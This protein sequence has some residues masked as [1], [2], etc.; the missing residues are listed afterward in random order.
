MKRK[1]TY[2]IIILVL[3]MTK[4]L[5][6]VEQADRKL[7]TYKQEV[8][9]KK[10]NLEELK[11]KIREKSIH[12]EKLKDKENSLSAE[13]RKINNNL[14]KTEARIKN[15]NKKIG[16]TERE[17]NLLQKKLVAKGL[18]ASDSRRQ[19]RKHLRLLYKYQK[20]NVEYLPAILAQE[21]YAQ[22]ITVEKYLR[23]IGQKN[24]QLYQ[25]LKTQEAE[26]SSDKKELEAKERQ[27]NSL[28]DDVK[29]Q[30]LVLLKQQEQRKEILAHTQEQRRNTED[31]ISKLRQQTADLQNLIDKFRSKISS[32]E[33][34]KS[35]V[36]KSVHTH[37]KGELDWPAKGPVISSFGKQK[38]H[39]L[40]A[41]VINN[42]VEIKTAPGTQ[43]KAIEKGKILYANSFKGYGKM[44]IIDHGDDFY[45]VYA[46][47]QAI[48]VREDE[49]VLKAQAIG[50]VDNGLYFEVRQDGKPEDPL[51]WLK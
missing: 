3:I 1:L 27:L 40:N 51:L 48:S 33:K 32:L 49:Q 29:A 26:I 10:K 6:S 20:M 18:E 44:V 21:S 36:R 7:D 14:A 45:T 15:L 37:K 11:V 39:Q 4:R 23:V 38:N 2:F 13:L 42:G 50:Q 43:V 41:Y 16:Q 46:H 17:I 34:E 31:E 19:L 25:Q 24:L 12:S 9:Q 22:L 28:R 35:K 8:Q 47:L 5:W 30:G